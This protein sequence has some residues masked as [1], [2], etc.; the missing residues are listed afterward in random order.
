MKTAQHIFFNYFISDE[1]C[2]NR[3]QPF[4]SSDLMASDV[5]STLF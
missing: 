1:I 5:I 2:R 4:Q 3:L